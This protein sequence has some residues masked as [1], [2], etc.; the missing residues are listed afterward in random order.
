[1]RRG[2]KKD[3]RE[4]GQEIRGELDLTSV[5]PLDPW[6]LAEHVD[7]PVWALSDLNGSAS[8]CVAILS[9][10]QRSAFSAMI[11]VVGHRRVI[12]HNDS[13]AL[14][15]QR[16][17]IGHELAH[18]LLL[19]EPHVVQPGEPPHF[20]D[21]QEDEAKWLGGVLLVPDEACLNAC[22]DG[23]SV[24]DAARAMGVSVDLMRW[25]L[26]KSG[27]Q[28]RVERSRRARQRGQS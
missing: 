22:R 17:N 10:P 3:A 11:A 26:N 1:M 15:R 25:R 18:A 4:I 12:L 28:V 21:E 8:D 6:K 2:F 9:G 27:A 14:T 16:A 5:Q 24:A 7:I 20:D 19:H 13:H 23:R